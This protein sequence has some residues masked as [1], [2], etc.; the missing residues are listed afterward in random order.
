[1]PPRDMADRNPPHTPAWAAA[2][3]IGYSAWQ[4][5]A[6]P[7]IVHA[8]AALPVIRD[9]MAVHARHQA[10]VN[11]L[12]LPPGPALPAAATDDPRI[13]RSP[14]ARTTIWP[15]STANRGCAA[16]TARVAR[17]PGVVTHRGR[18][19]GAAA[20]RGAPVPGR[21]A[22]TGATTGAATV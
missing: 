19:A 2:D 7:G 3:S 1:M 22:E 12:S 6:Q 14:G 18:R 9:G 10:F 21:A 17:E 5:L 8:P 11:A 13:F 16:G 4:R 20:A 15:R